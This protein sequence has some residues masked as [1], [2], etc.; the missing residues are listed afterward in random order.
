[1]TTAPAGREKALRR[2]FPAFSPEPLSPIHSALAQS[3][4]ANSPVEKLKL[5]DHGDGLLL[6]SHVR[7]DHEYDVSDVKD[8][9]L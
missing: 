3:S 9:P 4:A 1:M 8:V 7:T 5:A 2:R 6:R